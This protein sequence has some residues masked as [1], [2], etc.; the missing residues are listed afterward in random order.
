MKQFKSTADL[1]QLPPD[2]PAHHLESDLVR[3]LI[4]NYEAEGYTHDPDADGWIVLIE[5]GDC[6]G[7]VNLATQ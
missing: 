7:I 1:Q 5:T 3:R 2:D 6:S 4:V